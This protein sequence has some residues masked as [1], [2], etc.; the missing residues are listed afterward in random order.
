VAAVLVLN[1]PDDG[2]LCPKHEEWLCRNK[3]CRVLH[4][5]GVSFPFTIH[6]YCKKFSTVFLE[7]FHLY[8]NFKINFSDQWRN[9][10]SRKALSD[11][12]WRNYELFHLFLFLWHYSD[13]GASNDWMNN[14]LWSSGRKQLWPFFTLL[15]Q[16]LPRWN[17]N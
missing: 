4:Q 12:L 8:I 17:E 3:T 10:V 16:N 2:R 9:T 5:I 7:M 1:N 13:N 11:I 6:I 14:E 15:T